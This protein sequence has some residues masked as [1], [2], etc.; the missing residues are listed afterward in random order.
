VGNKFL[1]DK[2]ANLD[3]MKE[4]LDRLKAYLDSMSDRVEITI[5]A[6]PDLKSGVV[7]ELTVA[8]ESPPFRGRI[9]QK[10]I[11]TSEK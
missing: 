2:D 1:S 5:N 3:S 8:L 10:Y 6:H 4:L 7:R 9:R 11:G